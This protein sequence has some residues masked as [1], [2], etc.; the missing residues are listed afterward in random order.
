MPP[1]WIR[2]ASYSIWVLYAAVIHGILRRNCP[3]WMDGSGP[4]P[5]F[6]CTRCPQ[7]DIGDYNANQAYF[8]SIYERP[9]LAASVALT[10]LTC[11]TAPALLRRLR[12]HHPV[13]GTSAA[14]AAAVLFL[15]TLILSDLG[16]HWRLHDGPRF[17]LGMDF[18]PY[19]LLH[20]S[21]VVLV[22][23]VLAGLVVAIRENLSP[24]KGAPGGTPLS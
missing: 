21:E 3:V 19:T 23:P 10:L 5:S 2:I 12:P 9:Y 4:M 1:A 7:P 16:S 20:V 13:T 11:V 15:T 22:P 8:D 14:L 6:W 18:S 17:L 24:P